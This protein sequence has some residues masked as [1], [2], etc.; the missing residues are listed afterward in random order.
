MK[1]RRTNRNS[2][3]LRVGGPRRLPPPRRRSSEERSGNTRGRQPT[4]LTNASLRKHPQDCRRPD[5]RQRSAP[6]VLRPIS[7]PGST[8]RGATCF[9]NWRPSAESM[10]LRPFALPPGVRDQH[11]GAPRG[12]CVARPQCGVDCVALGDG[13]R[14]DASHL[15]VGRFR[16]SPREP[17]R[18]QAGEL[19][20]EVVLD[21]KPAVERPFK[22]SQRWF[23]DRH[24]NHR[25]RQ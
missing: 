25:L 9:G 12:W 22:W 10:P 18:Q 17:R 15:A 6:G 19:E 23:D 5:G 2:A 3:C 20:D 11:R 4:S 8:L 7:P 24:R 1:A 21:G 13:E 14:E 16:A